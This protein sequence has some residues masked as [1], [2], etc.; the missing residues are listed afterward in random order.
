[1]GLLISVCFRGLGVR[2]GLGLVLH[3]LRWFGCDLAVIGFVLLFVY[4]CLG[5]LFVARC[6]VVICGCLFLVWVVLL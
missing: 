1:M 2:V 5:L 4:C 3:W 6:V